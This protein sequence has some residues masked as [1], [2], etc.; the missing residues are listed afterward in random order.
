MIDVKFKVY[1][2]GFLFCMWRVWKLMIKCVSIRD[3]D[4][5]DDV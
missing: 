3:R 2:L 5:F 4:V 1:L